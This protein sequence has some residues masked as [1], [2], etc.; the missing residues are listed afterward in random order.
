MTTQYTVSNYTDTG[1]T[2]TVVLTGYTPAVGDLIIKDGQYKTVTNVFF[3]NAIIDSAFSP[4]LVPGD[5]VTVQPAFGGGKGSGIGGGGG[6]GGG[7]EGETPVSGTLVSGSSY[8]IASFSGEN[9]T[10]FTL[11]EASPTS[12]AKGFIEYNSNLYFLQEG[13]SQFIAR[14]AFNPEPIVDVSTVTFAGYLTSSQVITQSISPA[15]LYVYLTASAGAGDFLEYGGE[16]RL[17][18]TAFFGSGG[19]VGLGFSTYQLTLNEAFT[20]DPKTKF[21]GTNIVVTPGVAPVISASYKIFSYI[22]DGRIGVILKNINPYLWPSNGAFVQYKGNEYWFSKQ[23]T[24]EIS[25]N[26]PLSPVPVIDL[27]TITYTREPM[28]DEVVS[29]NSEELLVLTGIYSV[30]VGQQLT[31]SGE[32]RTVTWAYQLGES[33]QFTSIGISSNFTNSLVSKILGVDITISAAPPVPSGKRFIPPPAERTVS[34]GDLTP[35]IRSVPRT[36]L[37]PDVIDKD[38]LIPS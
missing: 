22:D 10:T 19:D 12:T 34:E 3:S 18:T 11:L 24:G 21:I 13:A 9:F 2:V 28:S 37:V 4:A 8:T 31:Y 7:E 30:S 14:P 20:L 1:E 32:T 36:D 35:D 5:T 25:V 16:T 33:G 29:Q 6:G 27:D 23:G 26:E 15:K 38:K 17:I